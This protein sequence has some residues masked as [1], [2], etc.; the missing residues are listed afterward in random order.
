MTGYAG[1]R[2][3]LQESAAALVTLLT[4]LNRGYRLLVPKR[5]AT[6]L[7]LPGHELGKVCFECELCLG[8]HPN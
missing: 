1:G 3:L 2:P 7:D 6:A 4:W 8:A 5:L